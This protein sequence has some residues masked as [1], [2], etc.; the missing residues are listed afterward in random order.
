MNSGG[1]S[2][3]DWAGNLT[4]TDRWSWQLLRQAQ[5]SLGNNIQLHL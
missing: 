5:H 3:D 2:T 4:A 1:A